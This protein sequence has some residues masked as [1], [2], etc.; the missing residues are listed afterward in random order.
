M[1]NNSSLL[2][3]N[4]SSRRRPAKAGATSV[5]INR[6]LQ[7]TLMSFVNGLTHPFQGRTVTAVQPINMDRAGERAGPETSVIKL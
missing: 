4:A 1:A 5:G 2:P 7:N 6:R 3:L